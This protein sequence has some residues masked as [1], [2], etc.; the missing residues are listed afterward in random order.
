MGADEDAAAVRL[1]PFVALTFAEA[2]LGGIATNCLKR[3]ADSKA[4]ASAGTQPNAYGHT[5]ATLCCLC[6][7]GAAN[8]N[9]ILT[10]MMF[11]IDTWRNQI[12]HACDCDGQCELVNADTA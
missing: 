7:L 9:S 2:A 12:T 11:V 3:E 1:E 8:Q 6:L 10:V 4:K 5:F